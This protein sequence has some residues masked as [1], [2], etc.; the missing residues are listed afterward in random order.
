MSEPRGLLGLLR[1]ASE[2][3]DLLRG[4]AGACGL[5]LELAPSPREAEPILKRKTTRALVVEASAEGAETLC[6]MARHLRFPGDIAVLVGGHM[7]TDTAFTRAYDWGADDVVS[8]DSERALRARLS[9]LPKQVILRRG[10]RRSALIGHPDAKLGTRIARMLGDAG[11]DVE[12][13]DSVDATL[14]RRG[15]D[16][17]DLLVLSTEF[18]QAEGLVRKLLAG[19]HAPALVVWARPEEVEL[20]QRALEG[21]D[22]VDV[23]NHETPLDSILFASNGLVYDANSLSARVDRRCLY[24]TTV[25]FRES[26]T[27]EP[28]YGFTYNIG[29]R[30]MYVRTLALPKLDRVSVEVRQPND[31]KKL[32][33]VGEVVWRRS[34]GLADRPTAPPGFGLRILEVPDTDHQLWLKHFNGEPAVDSEA[35]RPAAEASAQNVPGVSTAADEAKRNAPQPVTTASA[36]A[37]SKIAELSTSREAP[38]S[39][40]NPEPARTNAEAA[41]SSTREVPVLERNHESSRA[42]P[43]PAADS[44]FSSYRPGARRSSSAPGRVRSSALTG[45][46][47][48]TLLVLLLSALTVYLYARSHPGVLPFSNGQAASAGGQDQR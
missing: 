38:G 14:E 11:Y 23:L 33:M 41:P 48:A 5:E 44:W 2:H 4:A 7:L 39:T 32:R 40:E 29:P 13:T 8:L 28:D 20:L 36:A 21:F 19:A 30:G 42:T 34:F 35:A 47:L 12:R 3:E 6:Q 45:L 31:R 46:P 10:E 24:G 17:L 16:A 9:G 18:G 27:D 25:S 15:R 22:R 43:D 26:E 1:A 37:E